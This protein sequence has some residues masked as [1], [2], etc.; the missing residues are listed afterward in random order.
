MYWDFPNGLPF[1]GEIQN[2]ELHF[3]AVFRVVHHSI[4]EE[5][6]EDDKSESSSIYSRETGEEN[7]AQDNPEDQNH[8]DGNLTMVN[9][10]GPHMMNGA[11]PHMYGALPDMTNG[12]GPHMM[13]GAVPNMMN[14]DDLYMMS[15]AIPDMVNGA[16]PDV[17][18]GDGPHIINAD[19]LY[20][21]S[22]A[23]PNVVNVDDLDVVNGDGPQMMNGDGS[24]GPSD[25]PPSETTNPNGGTGPA[26]WAFLDGA[27]DDE[28]TS[29]ADTAVSAECLRVHKQ[30]P[31]HSQARLKPQEATILLIL[32]ADQRQ[33]S[34]RI[35]AL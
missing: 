31:K 29:P 28:F 4:D 13:Y 30:L 9:G 14:A 26:P 8:G 18:N 33:K 27:F 24:P 19:D 11:G 20:T 6:N 16:G 10:D 1:A 7:T 15:G 35:C 22:G 25:S 32:V 23:I 5:A 17:V 12:N 34:S 21:M 2:G 3:H